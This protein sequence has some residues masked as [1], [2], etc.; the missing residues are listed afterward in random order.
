METLFNLKGKTALIVGAG[1]LGRGMAK[2]L[3]STGADVILADI[4][5]AN[6]ALGAQVVQSCGRNAYMLNFDILKRDLIVK[7]V[8]EAMAFTGRLDILV[9]SVGFSRMGH[10]E[11]LA[12]EDWMAVMNGFLNGVFYTC[13][14]VANKAM[15]PQN[16]GKIINI[17]SISGMVITGDMG[18][19]YCTAKAGLI[20]LTKALATE[21]AKY[22][23]NVNC[24]S[25]G[26]MLT[27]LTEGYLSNPD[28]MN[29]VL[30]GLAK[31]R[32][33]K[34]EDLSGAAVFLASDCSD[35]VVGQNLAID[36]GYSSY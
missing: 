5:P 8:D 1:G 32:I 3:A 23:I 24:I 16:Y 19:S 6:A 21:W 28:V 17:A 29:G 22:N 34:P 18:S 4:N 33:G 35:Y 36:G 14:L 9:N 26:Y 7:M 25:P 2:G 20:Q 12:V 13:Q 27:P 15:I 11:D 31:K 30:K 10:A